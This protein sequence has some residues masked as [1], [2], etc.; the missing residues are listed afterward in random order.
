MEALSNPKSDYLLEAGLDVLHSESKEWQSE[1]ELMSDELRFYRSLLK[2]KVINLEKEKQWEHLLENMDNLSQAI[3]R[4]LE[5]DVRSHEKELAQLLSNKSSEDARYRFHHR[6]LRRKVDQL[7]QD[8]R[9]EKML[10]FQFLE[11][12]V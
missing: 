6:E 12:K 2:S 9:T 5:N 4:E 8:V 1:L 11:G 10:M 3:T 7:R